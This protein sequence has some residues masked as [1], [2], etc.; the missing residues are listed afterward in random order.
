M[1]NRRVQSGKCI[2]KFGPELKDFWPQETFEDL[3][4]FYIPVDPTWDKGQYS[5][6]RENEDDLFDSRPTSIKKVVKN[7]LLEQIGKWRKRVDE[8]EVKT[9]Q[10]PNNFDYPILLQKAK[11]QLQFYK[12]KI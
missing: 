3:T 2:W 5:N 9:K 11:K 6:E 7:H 8:W 12:N 10:F 1:I 4:D